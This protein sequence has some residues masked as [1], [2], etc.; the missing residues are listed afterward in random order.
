MLKRA[1]EQ[2]PAVQLIVVLIVADAISVGCGAPLEALS[3]RS[4]FDPQ[5]SALLI[6]C[7]LAANVALAAV[8]AIAFAASSVLFY[9]LARGLARVRVRR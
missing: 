3:L 7:L 8:V 6:L 2:T 1:L 9:R 4:A 5:S